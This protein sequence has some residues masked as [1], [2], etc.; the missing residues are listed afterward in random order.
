MRIALVNPNTNHKTTAAM[1]A[2]ALEALPPGSAIT[3]H[4]A[5]FGKPL[6]TNPQDLA[7]AAE[8]VA[9]MSAD[10]AA[11]DGVIVSAF[12]DPGRDAL[13]Q[14]LPCPVI[15][16]AEAAMAEAAR[17]SGGR[18]SVVTTTP[19]LAESIRQTAARYKL[20]RSLAAVRTTAED[21]AQLMADEGALATALAALIADTIRRDG[22][23]SVII[24]GGPLATVARRL[25][26]QFSVPVAEPIP[27]AARMMAAVLRSETEGKLA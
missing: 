18:F 5:P 6:I 21:P 27:V 25:A 16:I 24:G 4:T 8:A 11:F 12:G 19:G 9:A 10:L 2:I 22:A 14:V 7:I 15:G 20:D 23:R 1:A 13:K 3:G 17:L 26:P